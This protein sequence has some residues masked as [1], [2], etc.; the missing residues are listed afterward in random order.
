MTTSWFPGYPT[1]LTLGMLKD[2]PKP[3]QSKKLK[4]GPELGVPINIQWQETHGQKK[5]K[6]D[7]QVNHIK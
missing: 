1:L 3:E 2:L 6:H 7:L 4:N 5:L